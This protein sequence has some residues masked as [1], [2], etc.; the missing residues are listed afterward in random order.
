M[1]GQTI[2]EK[3]LSRAAVKEV[4]AG[5]IVN[6]QPDLAMATDGSFPMAIDYLAQMEPGTMRPMF[7]QRI[8]LALDHY[9]NSSGPKALAL[10]GK[11]RA[12]AREF[13][14]TLFDAGEG[15]GHQLML[16]SGRI[17]PGMLVVGADSHSTTYSALNC[18]ATGIGSSDLAGILLCGALWLRVPETIKVEFSGLLNKGVS[19]KDIALCLAKRFENGGANYFALEFHGGGLAQL[20]MNDRIVISNMAVEYGA[21]A[22]MFQ[23]D[24][25]T[26]AWLRANKTYDCQAVTPDGDARY[27]K[28]ITVDLSGIVP[29]LACPHSVDNVVPADE[30]DTLRVDTV[31]IGTCTAGRYEDFYDVFKILKE[32]G[33]PSPHVQLIVTPASQM[34]YEQLKASGVLD[35]FVRYG[36]LLQPPGCGSCCG[37]AGYR[38]RDGEVIISTANRNFKGRMGNANCFIYLASPQTCAQVACTG[39]INKGALQ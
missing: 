31:Y 8:I 5:D 15:V 32:N 37:T 13:G 23:F 17:R 12:Y 11:A 20:P 1:R 33:G 34:V 19:G 18:F 16:E 30:V 28:T 27:S 10:Q 24:E 26:G 36:A 7:P 4:Y 38:P 2:A 25:I 6:C 22:A 35:E 3:I 39:F 14:L 9:D 29:Q 21:K